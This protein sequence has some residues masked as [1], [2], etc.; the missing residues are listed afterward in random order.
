MMDRMPTFPPVSQG[1]VP[2][3]LRKSPHYE[4]MGM[5]AKEEE[6]PDVSGKGMVRQRGWKPRAAGAQARP[7]WPLL[8]PISRL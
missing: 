1:E 6:G 2:R 7:G 3:Q 5:P 8:L 4:L